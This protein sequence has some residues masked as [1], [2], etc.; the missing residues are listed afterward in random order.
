MSEEIKEC[1]ICFE[2]EQLNNKLF[3]PCVCSGT[4]KYVHY[5]C[6]QEWRNVNRSGVAYN[7][8]MEC[9]TQ[10]RIKK[11]F[12]H[13]KEN[14]F[15]I[16]KSPT[17]YCYFS[18]LS[19]IFSL[20]L[21]GF[22]SLNNQLVIEILDF[23]KTYTLEK[24]NIKEFVQKDVY[25]ASIFYYTYSSML[26]GYLFYLYFIFKIFRNIIRQKLYFFY[27]K[28]KLVQS[29]VYSTLFFVFY[30]SLVFNNLP[31]LA[32]NTVFVLEILKPYVIWRLIYNHNICVMVLNIDNDEIILNYYDEDEEE[33]K[34]ITNTYCYT[35]LDNI[36]V[37]VDLNDEMF[38]ENNSN[39]EYNKENIEIDI[40]AEIEL[41]N[42]IIHN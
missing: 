42:K 19:Y 40:S 10:Y 38:I 21:W 7:K 26:L 30:Y 11:N 39:G 18:L 34:I 12:P 27:I 33:G 31:S 1:R 41:E 5:N 13:E 28:K 24:P 16:K 17:V 4:S 36:E 20:V 35:E 29:I 14:I 2:G 15:K 8:C 32:L 25:A 22:D 23:N 9:N 6:L 3:S 37:L